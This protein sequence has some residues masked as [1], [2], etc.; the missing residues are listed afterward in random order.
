MSHGK[1]APDPN[2]P[3]QNQPGVFQEGQNTKVWLSKEKMKA[4]NTLGMRDVGNLRVLV[5][6]EARKFLKQFPGTS[7]YMCICIKRII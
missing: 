4:A 5:E 7:Q 6:R 2:K 1:D 3:A